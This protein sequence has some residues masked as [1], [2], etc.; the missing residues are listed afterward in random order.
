MHCSD[1]LVSSLVWGRAFHL[2]SGIRHED[3][4]DPPP[5]MLPY[6]VIRRPPCSPFTNMGLRESNIVQGYKLS[7]SAFVDSDDKTQ[8]EKACR[9][10][11]LL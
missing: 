5:G 11:H 6:E 4:S 7:I 1:T 10:C 2:C 9:Y 3:K 8:A